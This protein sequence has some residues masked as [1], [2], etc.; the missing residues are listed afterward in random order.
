M[1][2]GVSP[3]LPTLRRAE[4]GIQQRAGGRL[5]SITSLLGAGEISSS[6]FEQNIK[7]LFDPCDSKASSALLF[8]ML[9]TV[10][11]QLWHFKAITLALW[12]FLGR[13]GGCHVYCS[14]GVS[15]GLRLC[16]FPIETSL[17]TYR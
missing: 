2:T 14:S 10:K 12:G 17:D 3:D 9:T 4:R 11:I 16:F 15:G 13:G 7:L 6:K 5:K 1:C 8:W